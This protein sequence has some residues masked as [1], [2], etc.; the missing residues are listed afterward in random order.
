MTMRG[1]GMTTALLAHVCVQ[2]DENEKYEAINENQVMWFAIAYQDLSC[3]PAIEHFPIL[4][5]NY[6]KQPGLSKCINFPL[7]NHERSSEFFVG[8]WFAFCTMDVS[9]KTYSASGARHV[10]SQL[11]PSLPPVGI[12]RLTLSMP[13]HFDISIGSSDQLVL[14]VCNAP[15]MIVRPCDRASST[16]SA[17]GLTTK[18]GQKH[19]QKNKIE[20]CKSEIAGNTGKA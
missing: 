16:T 6:N 20:G 2:Y 18:P 3:E 8:K 12:M 17:P 5:A 9:E 19:E 4:L 7:Y 10:K 14:S 13:D 1:S 15:S 11:I